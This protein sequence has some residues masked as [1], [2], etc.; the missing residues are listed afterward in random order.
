MSYTEF[1][2]GKLIPIIIKSTLEETCRAIALEHGVELDEDWKDDF[3][4]GDMRNV[5]NSG[6]EYF[7][8]ENSLYEIINHE[9]SMDEESFVK[10]NKNN[11]GSISFVTQFYNGGTYFDEMLTEALDELKK[12]LE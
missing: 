3:K 6:K 11:D 7:I 2:T 8:Y 4:Y 12:E 10:L 1:H 5:I 9:E